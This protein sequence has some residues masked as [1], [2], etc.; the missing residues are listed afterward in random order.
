MKANLM[1][2][3]IL[4]SSLGSCGFP[5]IDPIERCILKV[6]YNK[7]RCHTYEISDTNVGRIGPS[8]DHPIEYCDRGVVFRPNEWTSM[9]TWFEEIKLY[10]SDKKNNKKFRKRVKREA[11]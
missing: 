4:C 3:L 6:E 9:R 10:L 7:C 5:R 11:D 2:L 8:V 1:T